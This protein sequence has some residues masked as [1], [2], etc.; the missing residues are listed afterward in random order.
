[1]SLWGTIRNVSP[2]RPFDCSGRHG[3][4]TNHNAVTEEVSGSDTHAARG[5]WVFTA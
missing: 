2:G 1:M 5:N 3:F 4:G